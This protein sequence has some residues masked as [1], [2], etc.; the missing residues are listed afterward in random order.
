VSNETITVLRG[1][2]RVKISIRDVVVGDV[3][4]VVTGEML[5]T[6]GLLLQ[7]S[8][9]KLDE[10]SLTGEPKLI[11]K[12]ASTD[13]FLLAG[14]KVMEGNGRMLCVSVGEFTTAGQIRKKVYGGDA[15]KDDDAEAA[16]ADGEDDEVGTE[17][18][19][20]QK[21]DKMA[22]QI[23]GLGMLVAA[24]AVVILILKV[25]VCVLCRFVGCCCCR[26]C[27]CCWTCPSGIGREGT[28]QRKSGTGTGMET[29][30][31]STLASESHV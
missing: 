7:G 29:K 1:G 23:G 12:T 22:M 8:D 30:K 28:G 21:L 15:P 24:L 31:N 20:F 13:P 26:C 25:W 27:C 17:S 9:M 4:E 10:S 3:I 2:N 14:T 16:D 5:A 11:Y 18:V 19:L 6:D